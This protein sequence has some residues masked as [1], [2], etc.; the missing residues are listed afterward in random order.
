VSLTLPASD[1]DVAVNGPL[2]E[3]AV[4]GDRSGAGSAGAYTH[5]LF[6]STSALFV[7]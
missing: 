7:G 5:S 1:I 2:W 3:P 6:S 4:A